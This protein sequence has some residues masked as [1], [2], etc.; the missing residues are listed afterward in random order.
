MASGKT[1]LASL[2]SE[3]NKA[4]YQRVTKPKE[5][6][7]VERKKRRLEE[8]NEQDEQEND[9]IGVSKKQI[10]PKKVKKPKHKHRNQQEKESAENK[11]LTNDN[12]SNLE[13]EGKNEKDSRTI[14]VGNIPITETVT[15]IKTYFGQF[16][17]VESVRLRSVPTAGTAVSE[18]GNQNLVKKVCVYQ[19]KF[20]D[21][22]GS[23]NAYVVFKS[24]G[25]VQASLA[26]NNR[27]MGTRHLRVDSMNPTLFPPKTSVFLGG[28][29]FFTDEE[30]LREHFAKVYSLSLFLSLHQASSQWSR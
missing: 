17:Q 5:F 9:E 27:L 29:P 24:A 18:A 22:K 21:Q 25:S 30:E 23:F 14:F 2:F 1:S 7:K 4:N 26:A 6:V 10:L 13:E 3:E 8:S 16:G 11:S 12:Q 28:L 19:G 20:G 15:S